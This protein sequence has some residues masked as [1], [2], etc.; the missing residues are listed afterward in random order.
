MHDYIQVKKELL[1][2]NGTAARVFLASAANVL[3]AEIT[4]PFN[5]DNTPVSPSHGVA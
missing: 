2:P 5:S 4:V 1:Q 3:V